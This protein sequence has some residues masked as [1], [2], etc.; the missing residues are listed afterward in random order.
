MQQRQQTH[1][2]GFKHHGRTRLQLST[3]MSHNDNFSLCY[4][5]V[6]LVLI[7]YY[8]PVTIRRIQNSLAAPLAPDYLSARVSSGAAPQFIIPSDTAGRTR[9]R[10]WDELDGLRQGCDRVISFSP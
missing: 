2:Q 1:L 5:L 4:F 7:D 3:V 6:A 10:H 8:S 9:A